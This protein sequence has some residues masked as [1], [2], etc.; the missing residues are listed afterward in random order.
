MDLAASAQKVTEEIMLRSARHVHEVTGSKNLC[1]AGGVA[2]NCVGN[3][4]ILR[5]GPFDQVWIQPAAGDAGGALGVALLIWYQLLDNPRAT[6]PRDGQTGSLLGSAYDDAE[7]ESFLRE[8]GATYQ[9]FD[10]DDAVCDEVASEIARG[11]VV[12]WFQGRM[13]FGPR[14][15]D[16]QHLGRRAG[17]VRRPPQMR[18]FTRA[19]WPSR[20]S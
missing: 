6:S 9:R 4:R 2:L 5:E 13:E 3:G 10:H 16:A 8:V 11:R 19:F 20:P 12:G 1:L 18:S 14:G 7:I 15:W 17:S